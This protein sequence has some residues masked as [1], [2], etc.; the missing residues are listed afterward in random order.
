[1]NALN[2]IF[3]LKGYPIQFIYR[4]IKQF[5]QKLHV[6]KAFEDTVNKKQ[7]LL[8]LPFLG[9]QFLFVRKRLQSCIRNHL[10]YCSLRIAFHSKTRL[11]ILFPFKDIIPKE[12][13]SQ[14][15]CKFT[16]SCCNATYYGESERHLIVR[17]SEHLGMATLTEK[18]IKNPKKRSYL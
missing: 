14:L 3:K 18:R 8:V 1:M 10:P 17:A 5:L 6:T 12:I 2:Q 11:S 16:C 7:L 15:V 4:H 9:S 13:R